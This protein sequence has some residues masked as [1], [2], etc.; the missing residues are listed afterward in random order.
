MITE[1]QR[2]R[3][4]VIIATLMPILPA[5]RQYRSDTSA[6]IRALNAQIFALALQYNLGP[7][8]DLFALFEANPQLMGADGLHP[9]AEGQTRLAE[10]FRDDI[11]RRYDNKSTMS[12]RLSTMRLS[13]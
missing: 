8:V 5:S 7:P 6:K 3:I 13:Q 4:D 1:A 10:A 11:V 2:R 9:S 12:S